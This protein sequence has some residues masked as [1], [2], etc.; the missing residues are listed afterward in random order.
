MTVHPVRVVE[1]KSNEVYID[2]NDL[3]IELLLEADKATTEAEQRVLKSL[4]NRLTS[5]RDRA[6]K[7]GHHEHEQK[8]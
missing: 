7:V 4:A 1:I 2:V 3:I 6:H 8:L 5:M